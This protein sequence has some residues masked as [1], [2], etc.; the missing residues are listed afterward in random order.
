MPFQHI[1]GQDS[2]TEFLKRSAE[3]GRTAHAYLF[4]GPSGTGRK[5]AAVNFAKMVNCLAVSGA[6]PCGECVSCRKIDSSNHPDVVIIAAA[7]DRSS[8]GI[9]D[10]RYVIKSIGLKPYEAKRKIYIIDGAG[11]LTREAQNAFLKTLEEPVS[12]SIII[13]IVEDKSDLV[14]TIESRCQAVRFF[15][16]GLTPGLAN[17]KFAEKKS[18]LLG[19]LIDGSF[20]DSDFDR[21][22]KPEARLYL[23]AMLTWYR[24]VLVAKASKGAEGVSLAN[25]DRAEAIRSEA[26][27]L[28]FEFLYDIIERIILTGFYLEQNANPKL[29]ISI[30]GANICTK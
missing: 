3:G 10:I 22:T 29:A 26:L 13:F 18:A 7:K 8:I 14:P 6:G 19:G 16:S 17:E 27:R 15:S 28:N 4:I 21:L 5:A 24:D 20:F 12:D 2:A 11:N 9:D 30:I 25:S 23:E 1:K